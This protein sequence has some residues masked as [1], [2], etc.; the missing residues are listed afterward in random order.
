VAP[1]LSVL[2]DHF[3]F[4]ALDIQTHLL[5]I[6][7]RGP[8]PD[9]EAQINPAFNPDTDAKTDGNIIVFN[10]EDNKV[11]AVLDIPQVAGIV[12]A[13]DLHKVYAADTNDSLIYVIDERTLK[14][15]PIKLQKNDTPDSLAYDATDHFIIVSVPGAPTNPDKSNVV[16]RKNQNVNVI[17]ARSDKIIGIIPLGVDGQWGDDVGHA[18]FDPGLHRIFVVVQ[19]LADPDSTDP[20]LLPPPGTA[21]LVEIDPVTLRVVTRMKLPDSCITPHGMEI[22]TQQ[23]IAFIACIDADPP[24]LYRVDLQTMRPFSE[25]PWSIPVKPDMVV[26]D[27]PL[28]LLFVACGAGLALFK[29]E[30]RSFRWLGT[31]TYGVNTHSIAVNEQTQEIY[32]PLVR[33]GGRPV[34]RIMKYNPNGVV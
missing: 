26:L 15:A 11:V 28:H 25:P 13:P 3:D 9:M 22:D 12:L 33:V 4:Q 16:D 2:F 8:N 30:G 19:Q 6:A 24:S 17:D 10:T 34:L 1:G 20:N 18:K 27:H 31:Y 5:F 7:H 23:H 14:F 32:L 21:R 29:E